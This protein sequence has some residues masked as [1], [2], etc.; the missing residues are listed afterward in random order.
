[1]VKEK[2]IYANN[3]N[4]RKVKLPY[5]NCNICLFIINKQISTALCQIRCVSV[6]DSVVTRS[7]CFLLCKFLCRLIGSVPS[8]QLDFGSMPNSRSP[9]PFDSGLESS[10]Y[11]LRKLSVDNRVPPTLPFTISRSTRRLH[12]QSSIPATTPL[13][14]PSISAGLILC[15]GIGSLTPP[16]P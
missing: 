10:L 11:F 9:P 16:R 1:M 7:S 4:K 13:F 6:C 12:E 14:S 8:S 3:N 15:A 2:E 5:S